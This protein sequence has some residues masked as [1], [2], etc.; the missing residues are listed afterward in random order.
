MLPN[1]LCAN[2]FYVQRGNT[3]FTWSEIAIKIP[4]NDS[5]IIY[6]RHGWK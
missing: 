4:A 6:S 1:I 3:H 2:A 5:T